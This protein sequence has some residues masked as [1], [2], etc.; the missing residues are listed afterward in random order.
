MTAMI[1]TAMPMF[2]CLFWSVMLTLDM[3]TE[4][5]SRQ[6]TCLLIF[7]LSA[8]VLYFGHCV[9]FNHNT[10]LIPVSDTLYCA[11][12][13]SVYPLYYIYICELTT[14]KEHLRTYWL[15]IVPAIVAGLSVGVLYS[16][17]TKE[18][19]AM[20]I[21]GYLY[22]NVRTVTTPLVGFQVFI[23]DTCKV[24]FALILVPIL[25]N[26]LRRINRYEALL[27]GTYADLEDKSLGML[28]HM[29]IMF[30][31][32]SLLSFVANIIGRAY[33]NETSWLISIPSMLFSMLLFTLG[34]AGY[35]QRFSMR[36]IESDE[37]MA[38]EVIDESTN[39]SE[40]RTRIEQL[41]VQERLYLSPNLKIVDLVKQLNTNRNYIY[42]AINRGKG[43]SFT[44][45][46]NGMRIDYAKNLIERNP[47]MTLAEVAMKSGFSSSTS[48]YRNFKSLTGMGPKDYLDS[49]KNKS[50]KT[51]QNN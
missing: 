45:Y 48:F 42:R 22:D 51:I 2:V 18:E 50:N 41:M 23:H 15:F 29:L 33:F 25:V 11:A 46:V 30:V 39:I 16:M 38:D 31:A 3:L 4:G 40:L 1:F 13:L 36:D 28:H 21:N 47:E 44:E 27:R 8:S 12:N 37:Q 35:R 32:I 20:F 24:L 43:I 10:E 34:Y 26:G 14:R 5:R 19:S 9:F 7:M 17:M 6:R 49:V